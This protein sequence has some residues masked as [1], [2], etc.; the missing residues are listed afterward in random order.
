M[1]VINYI[2]ES[3]LIEDIDDP[4]FDD[5]GL[6]AW[7]RLSQQ[8]TL[9]HEVI[10]R[11]QKTLTLKQ[12]DLRPDQRGYYRSMSKTNVTIGGRIAPSWSI[13][14][15]LMD[16]WLLDMHELWRT[17]DPIQMHIRFESAHPFVDGNGRTGRMLL[18]W[19]ELKQGKIP[20][21]FLN[22]EKFDKYYPLFRNN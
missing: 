22:S 19:H 11:L 15:A 20:T 14:E 13:V 16:N 8:E 10:R 3:N 6:Y 7:H 21:L 9:T 2:H 17:L 4:E 5:Q 12:T 18:W 1:N